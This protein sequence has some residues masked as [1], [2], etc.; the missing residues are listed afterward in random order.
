LA[1]AFPLPLGG[2][3]IW[4]EQVLLY[5]FYHNLILLVN[6]VVMG[7]H[8]AAVLHMAGALACRFPLDS[9]RNDPRFQKLAVTAAKQLTGPLARE[10]RE[11]HKPARSLSVSGVATT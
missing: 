11:I 4:S 3:L 2:G 7:A 8:H 9:L 10:R 5:Q 6:M 1:S